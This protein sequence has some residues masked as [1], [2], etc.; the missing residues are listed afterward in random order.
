MVQVCH[1][2]STHPSVIGQWSLSKLSLIS[3][4]ECACGIQPWPQWIHLAPLWQG[5][6]EPHPP[7][8]QA[9]AV[10]TAAASAWATSPLPCLSALHLLFLIWKANLYHHYGR[11]PNNSTTEYVPCGEACTCAKCQRAS[12]RPYLKY[13]KAKRIWRSTSGDWLCKLWHIYKLESPIAAK[14]NEMALT[15]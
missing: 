14:E 13:P 10:S 7:G 11:W 4:S 8:L 2:L 6:A 1:I 5:Q 3:Q 9:H 12:Q 15:H